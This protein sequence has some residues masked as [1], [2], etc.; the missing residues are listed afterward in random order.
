M[1]DKLASLIGILKEINSTFDLQDTLNFIMSEAKKIMGAQASS[2]MLLD[3]ETK[4]LY[5]NVATGG[6]K[7][8]LREIRVPCGK[9]FAGLVAVSGESIIINDVKGDGRF[10]QEVDDKTHFTTRN[11]ICVPLV[12]KGRIIGVLQVLNKVGSEPFTKED[13]EIFTAFSDVA[14]IAINNRD[15]FID[16]QRKAYEASALYRLSET[17][18]F[19]ETIEDLIRENIAIICEVLQA[20]RVSL[21][22]KSGQDL[23]LVYR[24]GFPGGA[25]FDK[26]IAGGILK[27]MMTTNAGV[28][29]PNILHD[30]RFDNANNIRYQ[31]KSFVAAPLKVKNQV[32]GFICI[33]ERERRQ[34][35]EY[36]D[37]RTLEMMA[38]QMVENYNHFRLSEEYKKKQLIETELSIAARLQHDILPRE[39]P[40]EDRFDIAA[41]N[42]PSKTVGGDFYDFIPLEGE[43]YGLVIADVSGKGITAGLFMALSRSFIRANF[44]SDRTPAGMLEIVNR[45][46]CR[47]SKA[48]MFVTCFCCVID[49]RKKSLTFSNAGHL[50]QYLVDKKTGAI[51]TLTTRGRPLGVFDDSRYED[52]AVKY[53]TGELLL[54]FTDGI[55]EATD[56]RLKQYGERRLRRSLSGAGTQPCRGVL[57]KVLADISVFQGEAEQADDITAMAVRFHSGHGKKVGM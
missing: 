35:F 39:F 51:K 53:R 15:L 10:Y 23:K 57:E 3:Q 12:V 4:E 13:L 19:C 25:V 33:T 34:P 24:A 44:T 21:I 27:Y 50:K 56:K 9:G 46:I 7:E 38:Q 17:I 40:C 26:I 20:K 48:G 6:A 29:S 28:F 54:L 5:F 42:I 11:L 1:P 37:L 30:G 32:V 22:M 8:V 31:D 41:I 45:Q 16:M 14:A 49:A 36:P 52:A 47:D 18:N 43:K 55:T 2:L